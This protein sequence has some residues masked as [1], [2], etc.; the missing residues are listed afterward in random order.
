MSFASTPDHFDA[1]PIGAYMHLNPAPRNHADV[2][3]ETSDVIFKK[4][5]GT[6]F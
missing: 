1:E 4:N 2:G 3:S 5:I 6:L